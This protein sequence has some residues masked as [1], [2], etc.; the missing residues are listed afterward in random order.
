MRGLE[1][2]IERH[3]M[4]PKPVLDTGPLSNEIVTV[5]ADQPDLHRPLVEIRGRE[6]VNTILD[7]R[8]RDRERIDLIRLPRLT[9]PAPRDAHPVRRDPNHSLP[10]RDQRLLKAPGDLP[11]VLDRPHPLR[12]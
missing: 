3:Q 9:L 2:G 6:A 8:S 7:H 1:L 10:G 5:I 12:I 4:P 11:A